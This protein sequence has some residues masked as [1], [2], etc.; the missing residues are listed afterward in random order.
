MTACALPH[1]KQSILALPWVNASGG[2]ERLGDA[3]ARKN[4]A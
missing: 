4:P 1:A 2:T 3:F